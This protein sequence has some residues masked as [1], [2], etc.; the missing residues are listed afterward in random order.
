MYHVASIFSPTDDHYGM[1]MKN[2]KGTEDLIHTIA[3]LAP[4]EI[5]RVVLTSSSAAVRGTKQEP[6][7]GKYYTYKGW[8]TKSELGKN[9]GSS[10]QWS[11]AASEK[12]AWEIAQKNGISMVSICPSFI[13]GPPN[14]QTSSSYSIQIVK[15]WIFGEQPVQSRLCVDIRDVAKAHRLAGTSTQAIGQRFIVSSEALIPSEKIDDKFRQI[16]KETGFEKISDD[17]H[18]DTQF[19]VKI[20][21]AVFARWIYP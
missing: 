13:F 4:L 6:L 7:N 2:V 19:D 17:I 20:G 15:S 16:A 14:G 3:N 12:K 5:T 8:N 1:A 18:A 11:K 21:K 10:Y 9:W